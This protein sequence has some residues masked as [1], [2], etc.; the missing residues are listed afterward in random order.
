[1]NHHKYL[2]LQLGDFEGE[3]ADKLRIEHSWLWLYKQRCEEEQYDCHLPIA[4]NEQRQREIME[5]STR[6]LLRKG[7]RLFCPCTF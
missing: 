1:M 3:N 6:L 2:K 5:V 7:I 4:N